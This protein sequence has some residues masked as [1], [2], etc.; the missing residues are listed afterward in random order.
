MVTPGLRKVFASEGVGLIPLVAGAEYL[1][2][3]MATPVLVGRWRL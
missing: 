2:R 3:E 1:V